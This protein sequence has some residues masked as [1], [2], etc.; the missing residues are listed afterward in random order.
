MF[1]YFAESG[2]SLI[3]S[4]IPGGFPYSKTMARSCFRSSVVASAFDLAGPE[5]R[6]QGIY[7]P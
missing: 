5:H 3:T 6:D 1:G 4:S 7:L 2:I